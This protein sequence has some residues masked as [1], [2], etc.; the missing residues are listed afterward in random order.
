[1]SPLPLLKYGNRFFNCR[2]ADNR[3]QPMPE[4]FNITDGGIIPAKYTIT[5]FINFPVEGNIIYGKRKDIQEK[6]TAKK[7]KTNFA[8]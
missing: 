4:Y 2:F 7:A 5:Y 8:V 1:M 6:E 3:Y